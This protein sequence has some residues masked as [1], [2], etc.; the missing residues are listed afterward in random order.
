M[1]KNVQDIDLEDMLT[2]EQSEMCSSDDIY[3][4]QVNSVVA[5]CSILFFFLC[6]FQKLLLTLL[7]SATFQTCVLIAC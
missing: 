2:A 3:R 4:K 1:S 7:L 5:F 6:N